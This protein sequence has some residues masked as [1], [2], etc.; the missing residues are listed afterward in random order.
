[1]MAFRWAVLGLLLLASSASAG[2]LVIETWI[3]Q[4]G[5]NDFS[6][7][8]AAQKALSQAGP[9]GLRALEIAALTHS[10]AEVRSR[11]GQIA[12]SLKKHLEASKFLVGRK[13]ALDYQNANLADAVIDLAKK[14]GT[15]LKLDVS[16]GKARTVTVKTGE[17]PVW[18]AVEAFRQAAG[19][20]EVFR[21]D[22]PVLPTG[23]PGMPSV[24]RSYYSRDRAA[25]ETA[26]QVPIVWS[27]GTHP[28][29]SADRTGAVR[30]TA[31]AGRFSANRLIR[32]SG[33]AVIHLDI[34]PPAELNWQDSLLV[35]IHK[36]EDETGRPVNVSHPI[37][38]A[39]RDNDMYF[40]R[41]AYYEGPQLSQGNPRLVP[42]TLRTDDRQICKLT[43]LE[44]AIVGE[45]T[46]PNQEVIT[47]DD[48]KKA[49]G[50]VFNGPNETKL[51]LRNYDVASNGQVTI[52]IHC[53]MP[54]PYTFQR[55]GKRGRVHSL[56]EE[57][58]LAGH[59]LKQFRFTDANGQPASA[60]QVQSTS[61]SSNGMNQS[62]EMQILFSP[63]M[64]GGPPVRLVVI[65]N[66]SAT[67]EVPFKLKN[68]VMP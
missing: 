4:L 22:P 65:G 10:D 41:F 57:G 26:N 50:V 47:I 43:S 21:E 20:M 31:M 62:S 56:W 66:R 42:V 3:G 27:E 59:S 19:L 49:L 58:G 25:Y 37:P 36:A 54:D 24:R 40:N 48:M 51:V 32:G 44:G 34:A 13:V 29:L 23:E 68:V 53:E 60:G 15:N 5:A 38:A 64:N 46:I 67:V 16:V 14:T 6:E 12:V 18:E 45:V 55:Q 9:E 35:R 52:K 39:P 8:E 28:D 30:V 63:R 11:A 33:Q 17:L 7:R 2:E 61:S 1:M